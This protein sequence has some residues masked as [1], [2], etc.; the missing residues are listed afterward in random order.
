MKN[1]ALFYGAIAIAVIGIALGVLYFMPHV[2]HPL[3]NV[4]SHHKLAAGFFI[5]AVAGIAAAFY[6]RPK[7]SMAK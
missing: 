5:L 4:N 3:T 1:S 2:Y 7:K 6:T